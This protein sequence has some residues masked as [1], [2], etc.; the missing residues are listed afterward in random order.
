MFEMIVAGLMTVLACIVTMAR[1]NLRRW[2]GY[3]TVV[4]VTFTLGMLY[5]FHGTFSGVVAASFAGLFMSLALTA[6][7]YVMGYERATVVRW[8]WVSPPDLVWNSYPPSGRL[9]ASAVS[10]L[11]AVKCVADVL[12]R[13]HRDVR[14][15]TRN[16]ATTKKGY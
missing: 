14:Y 8:N 12:Q 1:M 11:A 4:D 9:T 15:G 3:A 13:I 16:Q 5:M 2:L 7:R 10:R 6:L